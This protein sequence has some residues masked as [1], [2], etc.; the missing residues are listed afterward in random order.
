MGII[1]N[2]MDE[3]V[4]LKD[5]YSQVVSNLTEQYNEY[6]GD[7][8]T[9]SGVLRM[10]IE[11]LID[12]LILNFGEGS[13]ES[14]VRQFLGVSKEKSKQEA[15]AELAMVALTEE[16]Y[17]LIKFLMENPATAKKALDKF[18]PEGRGAF[19]KLDI[20]V[21]SGL[22]DRFH[23]PQGFLYHAS[24]SGEISAKKYYHTRV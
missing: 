3:R 17:D 23:G 19:D 6:T 7:E 14:F 5:K 4:Y 8:Q 10:L 22:L 16:E 1:V 12:D 9:R 18:L 15:Q 24:T 21:K 13:E 20:M 2:L 11:T